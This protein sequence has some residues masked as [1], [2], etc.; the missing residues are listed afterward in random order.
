MEVI[1]SL[2][3]NLKNKQEIVVA[4]GSFDGIH[5]GHRAIINKTIEI[6]EEENLP[7]GVYSFY[8]HPLK[9]I[10]PE[11]APA[12]LISEEQKV[13]LLDEMDLDYYFRQKFTAKFSML[14]FNKFIKNILVE[15]INVNH[16]IVGDDFKFGHRGK[17]T[18]DALKKSEK[19]YGF[20]VTILDPVK[21]KG[22]KVSSSLIRNLIKK[23]RVDEIPDYFGDY[24]R[25]QGTVIQGKGRGKQLGFPTANLELTTDY[26]LPPDGVYAAYVYYKGKRYPGIANFG[27][28]PT[29][30]D[31]DYSIEIHIM[32]FSGNLYNEILTLELREFIREEKTFSNAQQLVN[33]IKRDILYTNNLLCYN[34]LSN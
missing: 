18:T 23:G 1:E 28:K 2:E 21:V 19:K 33:R 8:P 24:Y 4:I 22:K 6:A 25:L 31:G 30:A 34:I 12:S 15:K 3:F 13:E 20:K 9:I 7:A 5:V 14:K 29:F 10:N 27:H 11:Q 17:G 16:I 26:A 32:N